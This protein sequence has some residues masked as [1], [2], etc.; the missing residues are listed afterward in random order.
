MLNYFRL[1]HETWVIWINFPKFKNSFFLQSNWRKSLGIGTPPK[2][3]WMVIFVASPENA[4]KNGSQLKS[5][6]RIHKLALLIW[7][8]YNSSVVTESIPCLKICLSLLSWG[9][10]WYLPWD[11]W[12]CNKGRVMTMTIPNS[13]LCLFGWLE[14]VNTCSKW[15]SW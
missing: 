2:Q 4:G 9:W 13:D 12:A 5:R 7:A 11:P 8:N 3:S 6:Y 14:Q 1:F 10:Y 15:W